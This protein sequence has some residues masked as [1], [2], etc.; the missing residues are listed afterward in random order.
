MFSSYGRFAYTGYRPVKCGTFADVTLRL[1]APWETGALNTDPD[2]AS[3][4]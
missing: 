1:V 3:H 2:G 4:T